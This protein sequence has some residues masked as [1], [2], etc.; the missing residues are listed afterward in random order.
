[1]LEG[2]NVIT[3][4]LGSAIS[5][6]K[7]FILFGLVPKGATGLNYMITLAIGTPSAV[8]PL[9]LFGL[10]PKVFPG[11]LDVSLYERDF[12]DADLYERD[13]S[14]SLQDRA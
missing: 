13:I 9:T 4:G 8:P 6:L 12:G 14:A 1:M 10:S 3:L 2:R 11:T 7:N 5:T